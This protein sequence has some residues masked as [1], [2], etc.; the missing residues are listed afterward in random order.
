MNVIFLDIDGVLNSELFYLSSIQEKKKQLRKKAKSEDIE[1]RE[2]HLEQIDPKSVGLL[3]SIIE[4]TDAKVVL[5][6][7]WR[8]SNSKEYMQSLLEEQGFKGELIDRTPIGDGQ[9]GKEIDAWLAVNPRIERYVILDDDSD[10]T[11]HQL[12]HHYVH[13]DRYCGI[14]PNVAYKATRILT[15]EANGQ[16]RGIK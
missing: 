6:S 5:S 1:W 9:R 11:E 10:M 16:F 14:S 13:C 3:N 2:Y 12:Q 15:G 8:K 7:S 4:K